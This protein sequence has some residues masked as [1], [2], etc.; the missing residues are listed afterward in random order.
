MF[1]GDTSLSQDVL[2][3]EKNAQ[4]KKFALTKL[5][6]S[7]IQ[8][9]YTKITFVDVELGTEELIHADLTS[10]PVAIIRG[11]ASHTCG[12]YMPKETR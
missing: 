4:R 6:Q 7:L 1:V 2:C 8:S 12:S 9:G 5:K 3:I 10:R 11:H